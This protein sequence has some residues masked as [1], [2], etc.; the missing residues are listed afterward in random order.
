VAVGNAIKNGENNS[1]SDVWNGKIWKL[2]AIRRP[3]GTTYSALN[4]VS[5]LTARFCVAAGDYQVGGSS[6]SRTL[7]ETW[8]GKT[9]TTERTPNHRD[10][11][12]GDG[13]SDLACNSTKACVAVGGYSRSNTGNRTLAERWNG[14]TWTIAPTANHKGS[15]GGSLEGVSCHSAHRCMAIGSFGRSAGNGTLAERWSGKTWTITPT[16]GA[17]GAT[18]SFL[19]SVSCGAKDA[20][21]AVG[22][23]TDS[24]QIE[25]PLAQAW[26]GKTWT[27][28]TIR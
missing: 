3:H 17:H 14:K 22:Y 27:A 26:N 1:F 13:L 12:N 10:G 25:G 2:R 8:N 21:L 9:W 4:G 24:S 11:P 16:P 23:E 15:A 18:Y 28:T 20:C 6:K 7:A 19:T 5:C